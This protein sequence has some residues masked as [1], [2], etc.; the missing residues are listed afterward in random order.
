MPN[1]LIQ[2]HN[3]ICPLEPGRCLFWPR[4]TGGHCIRLE[5]LTLGKWHLCMCQTFYR[6]CATFSTL[7]Y[8]S[9][10]W[11]MGTNRPIYTPK[12]EQRMF[13]RNLLFQLT[14]FLSITYLKCYARIFW[15]VYC[16]V[17][18]KGHD[19]TLA[20][21]FRAGHTFG[22]LHRGVYLPCHSIGRKMETPLRRERPQSNFVNMGL[23]LH[24]TDRIGWF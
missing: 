10:S 1:W 8:R 15:I 18:V 11:S 16:I 22:Y 13:W 17:V 19:I 23:Y 5:P 9:L 7:M 21:R 14:Y 2:C 24:V 20:L 3:G 12:R 6:K 4:H